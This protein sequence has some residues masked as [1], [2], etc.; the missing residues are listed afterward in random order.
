MKAVK[1]CVPQHNWHDIRDK[2]TCQC[3]RGRQRNIVTEIFTHDKV[4]EVLASEVLHGCG[5]QLS[6]VLQ[7]EVFWKR[8][9]RKMSKNNNNNEGRTNMYIYTT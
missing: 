9:L 6:Q 8:N 5:G 3:R 1:S 7:I 4:Q 2:F